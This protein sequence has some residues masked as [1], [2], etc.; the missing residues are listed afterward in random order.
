MKHIFSILSRIKSVENRYFCRKARCEL[1]NDRIGPVHSAALQWELGTKIRTRW[2]RSFADFEV[3]LL[4]FSE[5]YCLQLYRLLTDW[6]YHRT[7]RSKSDDYF[8]FYPPHTASYGVTIGTRSECGW[9]QKELK[10]DGFESSVC[11]INV[12]LGKQP[13][14]STETRFRRETCFEQECRSFTEANF[15]RVEAKIKVTVKT[16]EKS[17]ME[18]GSWWEEL[19]SF[20]VQSDNRF[21]LLRKN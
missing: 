8:D 12:S 10:N 18:R 20:Y 15:S 1:K 11:D 4:D 3:E 6:W 7:I 21:I 14:F 17:R 2:S 16:C 19:I 9:S 13:Y 5:N